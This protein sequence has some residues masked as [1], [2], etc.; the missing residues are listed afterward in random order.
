M[1]EYEHFLPQGPG[2]PFACANRPAAQSGA[3]AKDVSVTNKG[4]E[5]L[6]KEL[7][8]TY[9]GAVTS[10]CFTPASLKA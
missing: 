6:L 5:K 2:S 7:V 3:L 4:R 1:I 8:Y 10:V 9:N